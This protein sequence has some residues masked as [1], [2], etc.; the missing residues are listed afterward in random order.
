VSWVS[1]TTNERTHLKTNLVVTGRL[2]ELCVL[3]LNKI[4]ELTRNTETFL[5]VLSVSTDQK[6]SLVEDPQ[7]HDWI[8]GYMA[9]KSELLQQSK[10]FKAEIMQNSELAWKLCSLLISLLGG[11]DNITAAHRVP[12]YTS[13]LLCT[14]PDQ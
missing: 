1:S 4:K 9:Q 11:M 12:T 10:L 14:P 2:S 5:V 3:C 7:F 8:I 13:T 6:T